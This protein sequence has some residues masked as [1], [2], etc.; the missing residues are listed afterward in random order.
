MPAKGDN[1]GFLAVR[2]LYAGDPRLRVPAIVT[3][4]NLADEKMDTP[5]GL[6][7]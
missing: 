6:P 3:T 1:D 2:N 7:S 4:F 5:I